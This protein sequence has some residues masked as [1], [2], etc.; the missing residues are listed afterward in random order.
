[1]VFL[2]H[3]PGQEPKGSLRDGHGRSERHE[4]SGNRPSCAKLQNTCAGLRELEAKKPVTSYENHA[5][6]L[7]DCVAVKQANVRKEASPS[8]G[9]KDLRLH[10]NTDETEN[11]QP[12]S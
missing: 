6:S 5:L 3:A 9:L 12:L 1:M 7:Q 4:I 8:E 2:A 10:A 11:S